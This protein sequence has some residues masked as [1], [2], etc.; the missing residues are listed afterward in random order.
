VADEWEDN[1]ASA[2][3]S[4]LAEGERVEA[5]LCRGDVD[6]F[7]PA[8]LAPGETWAVTAQVD[9]F[10]GELGL[11]LLDAVT[12]EILATTEQEG[13]P[14]LG[15][16]HSA[17]AREA[18][19]VF[20]QV[21]PLA[22]GSFGAYSLEARRW[23]EALCQP[24]PYDASVTQALAAPVSWEEVEGGR[25]AQVRAWLCYDEEL[26]LDLGELGFD[27]KLGATA[28]TAQGPLDPELEL[29]DADGGVLAQAARLGPQE[30]L[31]VELPVAQRGWLRV[32]GFG[33]APGEVGLALSVLDPVPCEDDALEPN[34]EPGGGTR[35]DAGARLDASL[36]DGDEDWFELGR[37]ARG[38]GL[39]R[40]DLALAHDEV[41]GAVEA[42]LFRGTRAVARSTSEPG[43]ERL[44][45]ELTGPEDTYSLLV[46][47]R[48]GASLRYS[49][50]FNEDAT[51]ACVEDAWE[52]N[53]GLET[54]ATVALGG[55]VEGA[56][57]GGEDWFVVE[58]P[59][60]PGMSLRASL[61]LAPGAG[62]LDLDLLVDGDLAASSLNL[63]GD[64]V[65][66]AETGLGAVYHL[67]V[68]SPGQDQG[69]YTLSVELLQ[70]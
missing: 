19:P 41:R 69:A 34:D 17:A 57:C 55:A 27:A 30:S 28:T 9:G 33:G 62:N 43:G 14:R 4:A 46:R 48:G 67:V 7:Y 45:Y 51:P 36:C 29:L 32:R 49:L 60:E 58:V 2:S 24:D 65:L 11:T 25:V 21:R 31:R 70:R 22:G 54:T 42:L 59:S 44:R 8:P 66:E 47:S 26:W 10:F 50:G 5:T 64:E 61:A 3:A 13:G 56:L 35:I 39:T 40:L 38:P 1:D 68:Y 23:G 15:Y 37:L 20:L 12:R 52:P 53:E 18:R 63:T 16:T 6:W